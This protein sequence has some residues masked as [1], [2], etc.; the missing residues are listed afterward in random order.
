LALLCQIA[1]FLGAT[2]MGGALLVL[3][4]VSGLIA[5]TVLLSLSRGAFVAAAGVILYYLFFLR[6]GGVRLRLGI[7]AV[8]IAALSLAPESFYQRIETIPVALSGAR[9]NDGSTSARRLFYEAGLRMGLDHFWT[10]VGLDQFGQHIATYG[11]LHT[12]RASSAHNMYVSI[13]AEAGSIGLIAFLGLLITSLMAVRSRQGPERAVAKFETAFV[14]SVELG[15]VAL[16]IGG[17]FATL[18]YSKIFWIIL[19][20]AVVVRK[21]RIRQD[22]AAPG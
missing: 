9:I 8:A 5:Y 14:N 22:H 12:V 6:S 18:E 2:P 1:P 21:L 19:A 20:L 17:L 16:L 7:V 13:F 10:G 11:N 4:L 3:L 15:Y